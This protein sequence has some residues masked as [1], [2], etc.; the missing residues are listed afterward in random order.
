M[1]IAQKLGS[2][3]LRH[4]LAGGFVMHL[5]SACAVLSLATIAYK[6]VVFRRMAININEFIARVRSS[7]LKGN[8]KAAIQVC[9]EQRSPVASV[10]K[11][12]LLKYGDRS[13][14]DQ[15]EKTMESA[16]IHEVAYLEKHLPILATITS[17]APLLGFVG[18]V[19]G[20]IAAFDAIADAGLSD[21]SLVARGISM[22]LVTTAW[23]LIVAF[24]TQPFYNYFLTKVAATTR[25]IQT[26]ANIL[27][28][29]FDELDRMSG[30]RSA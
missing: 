3:L 6:L 19:L 21:P 20:M 2:D 8:M 26:A 30:I 13:Q 29:T 11:T 14:R 27:F 10:V 1:E 9:E 4:Y 16:A 25:E 7:L 28:E 22:A 12:G 5:I 17:A 23:G 15:I 24:F 18:T